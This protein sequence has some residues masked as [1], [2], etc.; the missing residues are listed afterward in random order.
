MVVKGLLY[1]LLL[2]YSRINKFSLMLATVHFLQNSLPQSCV[3]ILLLCSCNCIVLFTQLQLTKCIDT[4][5]AKIL[6]V[7]SYLFEI[8]EAFQS[9]DDAIYRL[10]MT[11]ESDVTKTYVGLS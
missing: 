10:D 4:Y 1:Y 11:L 5:T 2:I 6:Y 7:I 9:K 3:S 8:S